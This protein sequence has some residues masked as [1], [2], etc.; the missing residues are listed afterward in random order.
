M[1]SHYNILVRTEYGL[2]VVNRNDWQEVDGRR[3][4][5][6]YELMQSGR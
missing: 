2:M 3:F 6:G 5:V 1:A 4:G